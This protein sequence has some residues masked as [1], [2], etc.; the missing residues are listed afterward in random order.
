MNSGPEGTGD[1]VPPPPEPEPPPP[2]PPQ[3]E[4]V[5]APDPFTDPFVD[6]LPELET[7]IITPPPRPPSSTDVGSDPIMP[8]NWNDLADP[9]GRIFESAPGR[10]PVA[11]PT[12]LPIPDF[13]QPGDQPRLT[14]PTSEPVGSPGDIELPNYFPIELEPFGAPGIAPSVPAPFVFPAPLAVP[15]PGPSLDPFG[16]PLP[17]PSPGSTPRPNPGAS[18]SPNPL[19]S[20]FPD[21][22]ATPFPTGNPSPFRPQAPLD[23]R[24]PAPAPSIPI[25]GFFTEPFNNPL[26]DPMPGTQF[27]PDQPTTD[28]QCQ[29]DTKKKKPKKKTPDR[30]VCY[31]GTYVQLKK[32]IVYH[33]K[34]VVACATP[35]TKKKTAT[36]PSPSLSIFPSLQL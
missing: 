29:C 2:P 14:P 8:P 36:R 18:P 1:F 6:P 35:G 3:P 23:Y 12:R 33:R 15:T 34:E 5:D 11:D 16:E 31:R 4:F 27:D 20:P 13:D 19:A 24:P 22:F 17:L 26:D 30:T 28:D 9:N 21:P 10:R 25:P 7:V 32:G